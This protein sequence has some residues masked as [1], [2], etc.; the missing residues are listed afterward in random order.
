MECLI[1]SSHVALGMTIREFL[2]LL[3]PSSSQRQSSDDGGG[4]DDISRRNG[5]AKDVIRRYHAA[6]R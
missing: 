4:T 2:I 3:L 6:G 5:V 1:L